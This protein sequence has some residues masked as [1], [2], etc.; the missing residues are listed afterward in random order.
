VA[1]YKQPRGIWGWTNTEA[2]L[3]PDNGVGVCVCTTTDQNIEA[4]TVC[5]EFPKAAS[6]MRWGGV[7]TMQRDL[8]A[9][10]GFLWGVL[11]P[12]M[13]PEVNIPPSILPASPPLGVTFPSTLPPDAQ[14][15]N[16]AKSVFHAALGPR[17]WREGG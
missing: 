1:D 8:A 16:Q 17:G 6:R 3:V 15:A 4:A 5:M 13:R 11:E 14:Q 12:Q 9:R 2:G 7:W 10:G